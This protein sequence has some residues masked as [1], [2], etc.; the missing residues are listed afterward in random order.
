MW[1][2]TCPPAIA[3]CTRANV[4]SQNTCVHSYMCAHVPT[5]I[6]AQH[7]ST[8]THVY[9]LCTHVLASMHAVVYICTHITMYRHTR[10]H[11]SPHLHIQR[12]HTY[13]IHRHTTHMYICVHAHAHTHTSLGQASPLRGAV[14]AQSEHCR[15]Q[16]SLSLTIVLCTKNKLQAKCELSFMICM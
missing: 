9:L 2:C 8:C 14:A 7:M 3:M 11:A 15:T 1:P 13:T 16:H 5:H 6:H 12:R 10:T 4:H